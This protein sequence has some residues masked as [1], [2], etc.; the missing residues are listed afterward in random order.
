M[1]TDEGLGLLRQM[2]PV[3]ER[4]IAEH[5]AAQLDTPPGDLRDTL[6]RIAGSAR[7]ERV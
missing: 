3:Y 1:L 2:W 4:G 5:F 7:G 6:R